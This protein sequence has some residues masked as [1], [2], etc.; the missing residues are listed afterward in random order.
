LITLLNVLLGGAALLLL[1][2][3]AVLFSEVLSAVTS[4]S[5][6][7]G[8]AQQ[9]LE[10][11]RLAVLMPAHNESLIIGET[12]SFVIPQLGRLDRLIVVADNCTD[13]TAQIARAAGAEVVTR[14]DIG[15]RGKGYAL[16][17]GVRHLERDPPEL[18]IVVDADCRL[19][20]GCIDRLARQCAQTAR[21]IQALYLMHARKDAGLKMRIAEFAWVVKNLVRPTGL[22]R[23]GLPCQLMG[24]GMAFPWACI[25]AANLATGHIV[26]DLNLGIELARA[27]TPPLF[28]PDA[29]VMSEFPSSIAGIQGQRTRWEH[30]HIGVILGEV[31][32]L[33]LESLTRPSASLMALALD[34][35]VPPLALLTLEVVLMSTAGLVFYIAAR[36]SFP[37][38]VAVAT[39]V[40]LVLSILLS[41]MRYGRKII[42][43]GSLAL[44][45]VY[46][47]WKIPLY[48]RFVVARQLDWVRSKRDQDGS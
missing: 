13:D 35:G 25:K 41:W 9:T 4:P 39:A 40:L 2:P 33:L 28:C 23:L 6:R 15:R 10:R 38:E 34:L 45:A 37:L 14:T 48:A 8:Q 1:V 22:N 5:R 46:A 47:F 43:L 30:G 12:L 42:S 3:V 20:S 7:S 44:A 36:A 24:T 16:D 26:E 17:F 21:P 32:R 18:V 11:G 29:L 27:G 19:A 31:P